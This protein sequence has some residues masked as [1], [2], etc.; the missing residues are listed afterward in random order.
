MVTSYSSKLKAE[1]L[2]LT[3]W[4]P[5]RGLADNDVQHTSQSA[6]AY[7]DENCNRFANPAGPS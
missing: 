5:P 7:L 3:A 1:E 6:G 4:L 2:N